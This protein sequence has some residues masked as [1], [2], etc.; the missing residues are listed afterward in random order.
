M[1]KLPRIGVSACLLGA[2]VRFNGEHKR[3]EW[4]V[5]RLS[6]HS[7]LIGFCPET[8]MGLPTP[9]PALRFVS[10][11]NGVRLIET[12]SK[13]DHT[14]A[15]GES[16]QA[17]VTQAKELDGFILKK[18]SPSC[19][20]ERVKVYGEGGMPRRDGVGVFA[21]SLKNAYPLI[22]MIEE[23][24]LTH[25]EQRENFVLRVFAHQKIKALQ[26]LGAA[27]KV[28]ELQTFHRKYKLVLLE[29]SPA[30]YPKLGNV[31]SGRECKLPQ[32]MLAAY[33]PTFMGALKTLPTAGTRVN[34]LQHTLAYLRGLA[35]RQEREQ[36]AQAISEYQQGRL[37]FIA[38]LS[39]IFH[40]VQKFGVR[41]LLE[42]KFFS[43]FP[44]ELG[45][46]I[47]L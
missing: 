33:A 36:I 31:V 40:E 2:P 3:N 37:P 32:E 34:V 29:H 19:G 5:D 17:L 20:L 47:R 24:R 16:S 44:R 9:R 38:P 10:N 11:E 8:F 18:D 6:R 42:Q 22:P 23:G 28:G 4:I 21:A 35:D 26:L 27:L 45:A 30:L 25:F 43:P 41:Y 7:D 1:S 12:N 15:A 46:L 39:L 13:F 14:V